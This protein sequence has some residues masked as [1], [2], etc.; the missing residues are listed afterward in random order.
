[1]PNLTLFSYSVCQAPIVSC[2]FGSNGRDCS[3]LSSISASNCNNVDL[4]FAY[5]IANIGTA[6]V[7]FKS[8]VGE[9]KLNLVGKM[10]PNQVLPGS[11]VKVSE[12]VF[13]NLCDGAVISFHVSSEAEVYPQ[14]S[15]P[16]SSSTDFKLT[17]PS[18]TFAPTGSPSAGQTKTP[19]SSSPTLFPTRAFTSTPTTKPTGMPTS[20]PTHFPVLPTAGPTFQPTTKP[21]ESPTTFVPPPLPT[22]KPSALPTPAPTKNPSPTKKPT[23]H[24]THKPTKQ[25]SAAPTTSG[26]GPTAPT[27]RRPTFRPIARPTRKPTKRPTASPSASQSSNPTGKPT[28]GTTGLPVASPTRKPFAGGSTYSPTT[29]GPMQLSTSKPSKAPSAPTC[30][31]SVSNVKATFGSNGPDASQASTFLNSQNCQNAQIIFTYSLANIGSTQAQFNSLIGETGRDLVSLISPSK[32]D[33]GGSSTAQETITIN[34][35][36]GVSFNFVTKAIASVP[37]YGLQ[38]SCSREFLL[39]IPAVPTPKP[40]IYMTPASASP[41]QRPH[42]PTSAPSTKFLRRG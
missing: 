7:S 23:R 28:E 18:F 15:L 12:S 21:S 27:T 6:S 5:S 42:S 11:V 26:T 3:D 2:K 41:S 40:N 9:S 13:M 37:P 33:I 36:N 10:N 24:P 8:V 16:C 22:A 34:A 14:G 20:S 39:T 4:Q 31:I 32:L 29:A 19:G 17:L 25:P 38:C 35:C 30:K 1:M